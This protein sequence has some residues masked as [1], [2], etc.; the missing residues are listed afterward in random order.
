LHDARSTRVPRC[1]ACGS[2]YALH[3]DVSP[4]AGLVPWKPKIKKLGF[5]IINNSAHSQ[6]A[7][8]TLRPRVTA[9]SAR[10]ANTRRSATV[11]QA[12]GIIT[13]ALYPQLGNAPATLGHS[14]VSIWLSGL[15]QLVSRVH[16]RSEAFLETTRCS[17]GSTP[18]RLSSTAPGGFPNRQVTESHHAQASQVTSG[19]NRG[20][21]LISQSCYQSS[22]DE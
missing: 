18:I 19:P 1:V 5:H 13:P 21:R 6:V 16:I 8:A 17:S 12:M 14:K 10:R 3:G 22:F 9:P 20:H 15:R 7:K 4:V 11:V 2:W